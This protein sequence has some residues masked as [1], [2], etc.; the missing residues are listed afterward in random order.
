LKQRDVLFPLLFNF[1]LECAIRRVQANE[2]GFT[3]NG[4]HQLLVCVDD[5]NII[6]GSVYTTKENVEI[7]IVVSKEIIL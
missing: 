6:G 3:L 5:V 4:T 2:H 7:L 1:V